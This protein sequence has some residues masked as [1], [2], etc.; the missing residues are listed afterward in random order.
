MSLLVKKDD[1]TIVKIE[2]HPRTGIALYLMPEVPVA[3]DSFY[4]KNRLAVHLIIYS[5][6]LLAVVSTQRHPSQFDMSH[7][8]N[9]LRLSASRQPECFIIVTLHLGRLTPIGKSEIEFA[10]LAPHGIL[11][12]CI[13]LLIGIVGPMFVNHITDKSIVGRRLNAE[14]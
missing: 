2:S 11:R 8:V 12:H 1:T 6:H 9:H 7:L 3:K 4:H 10:Q 5:R 14:A 13:Q